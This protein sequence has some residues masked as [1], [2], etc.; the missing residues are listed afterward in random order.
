MVKPA[1]APRLAEWM[2]P[3]EAA[4]SLGVSRQTVNSMIQIGEFA[5]LH[6]IGPESRPQYLIERREVEKLQSVRMYPIESVVVK[7]RPGSRN[8]LSD[9]SKMT[10][11]GASEVEAVAATA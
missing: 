4:D 7:A 6:K 2:T 8:V 5:T 11:R 9:R 3:S 10:H 1:D